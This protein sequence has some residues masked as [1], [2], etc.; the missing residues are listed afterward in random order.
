MNASWLILF[1][2]ILAR[3]IAAADPN[4]EFRIKTLSFIERADQLV[5][6]HDLDIR[7]L[8]D[9]SGSDW[10]FAIDVDMEA[11][12]IPFVRDDQNLF[13]VQ[14]DICHIFDDTLDTLKFMTDSIDF[15]R[16]EGSTFNRTQKNPT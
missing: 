10:T 14:N 13:Q 4:F 12:G 7:I 6:I 16:G 8:R 3:A 9:I 1:F 5:G 11:D 15:D 2:I